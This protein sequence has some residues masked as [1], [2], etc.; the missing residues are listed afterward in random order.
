M[1]NNTWCMD[2]PAMALGMGAMCYIA[3]IVLLGAAHS[4]SS[5]L[6]FVIVAVGG[7]CC[8]M[9]CMVLYFADASR[10]LGKYSTTPRQDEDEVPTANDVELGSKTV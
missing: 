6:D 7:M 9:I 8:M 2:F 10:F 3:G 5:G 1:R 4:G